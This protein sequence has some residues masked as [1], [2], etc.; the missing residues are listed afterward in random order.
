MPAAVFASVNESMLLA[1]F[2]ALRD[3]YASFRLVAMPQKS[4]HRVIICVYGL[5]HDGRAVFCEL[6]NA[7]RDALHNGFV[8]AFIR[9]L[10]HI[11]YAGIIAVFGDE[12]RDKNDFFEQRLVFL[13]VVW[14]SH[15]VVNISSSMCAEHA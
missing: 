4:P 5:R 7:E 3:F 10:A 1:I 11:L 2:S 9:G 8:K 13:P 15:G 12:I 6:G 14:V